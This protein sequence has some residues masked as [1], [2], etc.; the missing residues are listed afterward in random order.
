MPAPKPLHERFWSKVDKTDRCWNWTGYRTP[1]GYG[2]IALDNYGPIRT[3]SRVSWEMHNEPILEG[4]NV[5]HRCDNPA[6]VRP[7]HLFL[8]T[9]AEN[10]FDMRAKGR[11]C[12]GDDHWTRKQ[13]E[14]VLRGDNHPSRGDKRDKVPRGSQKS[15]LTEDDVVAIRAA[16]ASGTQQSQLCRLYGLKPPAMWAIVHRHSWKH[17]T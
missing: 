1:K 6:C 12:H 10:N 17:V 2:Q 7:D 16:Y 13:P 9:K 5:L 14:R 4:M 15:H 8:G 11:H 3:A